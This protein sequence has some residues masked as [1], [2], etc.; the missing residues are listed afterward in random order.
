MQNTKKCNIMFLDNCFAGKRL[1]HNSSKGRGS[2]HVPFCYSTIEII[3][4]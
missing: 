4:K 1:F 3:L 2:C